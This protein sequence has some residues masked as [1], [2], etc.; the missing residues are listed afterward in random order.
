MS[1][2]RSELLNF[3]K[4]DADRFMNAVEAVSSR[5][6][7]SNN[8]IFRENETTIKFYDTSTS[9]LINCGIEYYKLG[10]TCGNCYLNK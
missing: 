10:L 4:E 8:S 7:I 6:F 2:N 9:F 1:K 3:S 5:T